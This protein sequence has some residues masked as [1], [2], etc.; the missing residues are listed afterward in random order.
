MGKMRTEVKL[1]CGLQ[2]NL[3]L[4]HILKYIKH[5]GHPL[6]KKCSTLLFLHSSKLI[7][8]PV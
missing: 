6:E 4:V 1:L 7:L 2:S 5:M 8:Q 3:T